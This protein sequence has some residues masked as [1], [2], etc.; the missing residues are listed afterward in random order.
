MYSGR[1]L[2][3]EDLL[4]I[5]KKKIKKP[6]ENWAFEGIQRGVFTRRMDYVKR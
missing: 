4:E 2:D 6:S 1:T 5:H 3:K